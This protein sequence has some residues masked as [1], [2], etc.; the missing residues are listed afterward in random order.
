MT[1]PI[2]PAG[3][4]GSDLDPD[5]ID[6]AARRLSRIGRGVS[7]HGE[8]VHRK[9]QAISNS[10][11]APEDETLFAVMDPVKTDADTYGAQMAEAVRALGTFAEAVRPIKAELA[12]IK[13]EATAF[14]GAVSGGVEVSSSVGLTPVRQTVAWDQDPV[15]VARN[16]A[17][18]SRV[19]SQLA[20]LALA[21]AACALGLYGAADLNRCG[22]AGADPRAQSSFG[23][24]GGAAPWGAAATVRESCA[25]RFLSGV[26]LG[27]RQSVDG[28]AALEGWDPRTRRPFADEEKAKAAATGVGHLAFGALTFGPAA[29]VG[30]Q[31]KGPVGDLFRSGVL[32]VNE[33]G[34]S[35]A[36]VDEFKRDPA[37][38]AGILAF[39]LVTLVPLLGE[40]GAVKN[41]TSAAAGAA[42]AA[43]RI[44]DLVDPLSLTSRA[45]PAGSRFAPRAR[46]AIR[47]VIP[48]MKVQTAPI[49]TVADLRQMIKDA[50]HLNP[51]RP[52]LVD[53]S[54][55]PQRGSHASASPDRTPPVRH[56]DG[57]H[58]PISGS[59]GGKSDGQRYTRGHRTIDTHGDAGKD[60]RVRSDSDHSNRGASAGVADELPGPARSSEEA[61]R[62]HP[63]EGPGDGVST[64]SP[65]TAD[66]LTPSGQNVSVQREGQRIFVTTARGV[67]YPI[68][69]GWIQR[70]A[71][72]DRGLVFQKPGSARNENMLRIMEPT[73][74]YPDGYVRVHQPNGQPVDVL[75][76]AGSRSSS[77]VPQTYRGEW[78]AWPE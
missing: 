46:G 51:R 2:D 68:P 71:D 38:A 17:L 26:G 78:P 54:S 12:A 15:S 9:W 59:P 22:Q 60:D 18:I 33:F 14:V 75:G 35:F 48:P 44:S 24:G 69:E 40:V 65:D 49:V 1:S 55:A 7:R 10:Y 76:K 13:S 74:K 36:A 20:T 25:N 72:N 23:Q 52:E 57:G 16:N 56:P 3:I 62:E 64:D 47:V 30:S 34:R 53:V 6:S 4:P 5:S 39:N 28:I 73:N 70:M 42:R 27:I 21:E 50:D 37:K 45:L 29:I 67:T 19:E 31:L 63:G 11:E 8:S 61:T 66:P 43:A 58:P 41:G 77:H 32:S